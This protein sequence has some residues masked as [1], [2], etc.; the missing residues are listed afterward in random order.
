M[1]KTKFLVLVLALA[2]MLIGAGYAYWTDTL[3]INGTVR[4]G[5][6]DVDFVRGSVTPESNVINV[7]TQKFEEDDAEICISNLYPGA[8]FIVDA[9][10]KNTGTIPAKLKDVEF[11]TEKDAGW[12]NL[13]ADKIEV[14]SGHITYK[15]RRY[16]IPRSVKTLSDMT[17][18]GFE[19][20]L[21]GLNIVLDKEE[22]VQIE[23][24]FQVDENIK[25]N[26]IDDSDT[27]YAGIKFV[28]RL[29]YEQAV[30]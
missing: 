16:E 5:I 3:K 1:K 20:W 22:H 27:E 21:T 10:I 23:F 30:K 28:G 24:K 7:E 17:G 11:K 6:L 12:D 26:G 14:V 9:K 25:D 13:G 2:V 29:D 18:R 19:S 15:N 4:T 8:H